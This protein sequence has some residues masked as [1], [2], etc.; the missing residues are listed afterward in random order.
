MSMSLQ[1]TRDLLLA[2]VHASRTQGDT[3]AFF[4][5]TVV[6]TIMNT[7]EEARGRTAVTHQIRALQRRASDLIPKRAIFEEGQAAVEITFVTQDGCSIPYS[8]IYD[9]SEGQ[10]TAIRFYFAGTLPI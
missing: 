10:I 3:A 7:G 1:Q 4:N 2:Y 5:D 6:S 8:V 9:C